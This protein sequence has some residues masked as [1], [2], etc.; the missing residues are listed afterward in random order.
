MTKSQVKAQHLILTAN[1]EKKKKK[2]FKKFLVV[3]YFSFTDFTPILKCLPSYLS[4]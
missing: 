4:Y 2:I 1:A 3:N